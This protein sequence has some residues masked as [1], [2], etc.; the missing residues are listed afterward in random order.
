M[1]VKDIKL[2]TPDVFS[3]LMTKLRDQKLNCDIKIF[4]RLADQ[5]Q[6]LNDQIVIR[7]NTEKDVK[8]ALKIAQNIL[9]TNFLQ[10]DIGF[11]SNG[12]SHSEI[13]ADKI[14]SD[15]GK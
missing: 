15:V 13:L 7:G 11:D 12:K 3:S 2:L 9:G 10:G 4:Q 5:G 8:Q 6:F 1:T 14:K